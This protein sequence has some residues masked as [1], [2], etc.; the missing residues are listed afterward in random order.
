MSSHP[1]QAHS[2]AGEHR[3]LVVA[4]HGRRGDQVSRIL[5]VVLA[6]GAIVLFAVSLSRPWWNFKLYAPQYPRGLT[7]V[8]AL[9]GLSGDAAEI[10]TLNHYIGMRSLDEAAA[11][12]RQY[13]S[14]GV[15]LVGLL[16]MG[17]VLLMGKR[18][19]WLTALAGAAFPLGF[20][21]DSSYW[22]YRF[23]HELDPRAPLEIPAFTPQLFGNG[24]IGQFMTFAQPE[25]G[26]WIAVGAVFVLACLVMMRGQV[27]ASCPRRGACHAV[28]KT[29]FIVSPQDPSPGD[30]ARPA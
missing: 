5:V 24:Q 23:G 6:V 21:A 28:C 17:T 1:V 7:L 14:Y 29:G 11:F 12:E 9:T 25:S 15:A 18:L 2:E 13:A 8:I 27:C 22:L 3:H 26:F 19:G 10:N 20:L 16:V 30:P 4:S